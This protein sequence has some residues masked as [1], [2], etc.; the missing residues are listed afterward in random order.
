MWNEP[1][2][3]T[4]GSAP[5]ETPEQPEPAYES[6]QDEPSRLDPAADPRTLEAP[7]PAADEEDLVA[8]LPADFAAFSLTQTHPRSGDAKAEPFEQQRQQGSRVRRGDE[9]G[10]EST[11][12]GTRRASA[13]TAIS[14]PTARAAA[15]S[16]T[17]S[18]N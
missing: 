11:H 15:S 7:A 17:T 14:A 18:P 1:A 8:S 9:T 12:A 6:K 16:H 4:D 2:A 3:N 13:S 5:A 10:R